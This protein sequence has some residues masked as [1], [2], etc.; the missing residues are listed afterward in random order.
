[1]KLPPSYFDS[2][3][4]KPIVTLRFNHYLIL[5]E[6]VDPE[7]VNCGVH[8]DNDAF[9][10]LAQDNVGG[11]QL[12]LP[13]GTFVEVSPIKDTFVINVGDFLERWSNGRYKAPIHRVVAPPGKERYS[14]GYHSGVDYSA[15]IQ[16]CVPD[17]EPKFPPETAGGYFESVEIP[18]HLY[19]LPENV[20]A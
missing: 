15:I 11:L 12:Q 2:I 10:V 13:D 20:T 8:T 18:A 7:Q 9:T 3:T 6:V 5:P 1:M 14:I 4:R 19:T 17:E 16:S